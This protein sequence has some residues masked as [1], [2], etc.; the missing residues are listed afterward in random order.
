MGP[1][2]MSLPAASRRAGAG[3]VAIYG[4][5]RYGQYFDDILTGV[6][7][8]AR[9]AGSSVVCVQNSL[10]VRPSSDESSVQD[11]VSRVGWDHFD[12]A[13]VVLQAASREFVARL[14]AAGKFVVA[15]GQEPRGAHAVVALD[16]A[17]G[18]RDAVMHLAG[19][20]HTAIG[21]VSPRWQV[22]TAQRYEAYAAQMSELGLEPRPLLGGDQSP[23]VTMDEQGYL[24]GREFVAS[25]DR[26]TAVMVG[27]DLIA[28]GF[29]R[30][31]AEA[32]VSVPGD[33]AL[34]GIDDI[35]QAAVSSP[36][37]ATV[38]F[39]F[40]SLGALAVDIAREGGRGGPVRERHL[41]SP[42]F[43]PRESCGC[44]S[45]SGPA[46]GTVRGTPVEVFGAALH[47]A[48]QEGR[49]RVAVDVREVAR[50]A[51]AVLAHLTDPP[52]DAAAGRAAALALAARI[53]RLCPLDRSVES[54][55][56]AVRA[57]VAA[58]VED[59]PQDPSRLR[60]TSGAALELCDAVRSEQ[61]QR[62]MR[63]Y[64]ELKRAQTSHYVVGNTL[65]G[66]DPD[67][68][69]SL[70]W[71]RH[72]ATEAGALGLWTPPGQTDAIRL[73]GAFERTA[74]LADPTGRTTAGADVA[75]SPAVPVE[76]FPPAKLLGGSSEGP[77]LVVVTH[78]RFGDS[79]W[80]LLAA[81]GA[82]G[83]RSSL[84]HETFQQWAVLM[85][86]ALDQERADEGLARQA[87]ALTSAYETEVALLEEVRISEERYA[88][89]AEAAQD[90]LWDWDLGRDE[91]FYSSRWKAMLGHR[92]TEV[93]AAPGEWL[94]RVHPEDAAA[95][96][97]QLA[98]VLDGA[99]VH[100]DVE[101]RL[102]AS[103]GE[104]RWVACIARSVTDGAGRPVRLVGTTTDVTVSRLLKE[105]LLQEALFD[106]L[107]GLAKATLFRDRITQA[108][109]GLRRHPRSRFA[110]LFVDLDGFKAVNDTHGHGVGDALLAS[111]ATR[112]RESLRGNDTAARLGGDEFGVL[113][114]DAGGPA[115]LE[116]V[117]GRLRARVT[118]PHRLGGRTLRVGASIGVA[119]A[120][121]DST[122]DALLEA[123]DAAMYREKHAHGSAAG[124]HRR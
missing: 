66:H 3:A 56:R 24:A 1:D 88:L 85:S 113:L 115:E 11:A 110:V 95:L 10:G 29:L 58:V 99:R 67:A 92:D 90:A 27:T 21:F 13:I 119:V 123:A 30:A 47:A 91:V 84:V 69:R 114:A 7:T 75:A 105:Q 45:S 48:S 94:D 12:S 107:T 28:L 19:H 51:S 103:S 57:A 116:A 124:D 81:A 40:E 50:L 77:R 18:V 117:V 72:T 104:Y 2:G 53:V 83:I 16:N 62:R 111:V 59:L 80:G 68:L 97:E 71:L 9:A 55:L 109:E 122:A 82:E 15:I 20:G 23:D 43:V 6:V 26:C 93:G 73:A 46:A 61:L 101:H 60:A 25:G 98:E 33:V 35:D 76:S 14:R 37:L 38:A 36:P 108:V 22:D 86:A 78:V 41:V 74:V 5:Y 120:G 54:A 31:L 42:R 65:L 49:F 4:S 100:L 112:L 121:P 44:P 63:E 70:R 32:G 96:R 102:R 79:D 87:A 64:V 8:A 89:A 106:N 34:V 52:S 17:R 39:S 118:A